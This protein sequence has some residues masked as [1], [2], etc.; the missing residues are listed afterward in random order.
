MEEFKELEL[1][2]RTIDALILGFNEP[3]KYDLKIPDAYGII[4]SVGFAIDRLFG[5]KEPNLK[6]RK[7]STLFLRYLGKDIIELEKR[8]KEGLKKV[9]V[10]PGRE[11]SFLQ[12]TL[13]TEYKFGQ[14]WFIGY[15][16]LF[17]FREDEREIAERLV[18][19][20]FNEKEREDFRKLHKYMRE[21]VS[22]FLKR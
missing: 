11:N 16:K 12:N 15:G 10:M 3:I 20:Y 17:R 5:R 7:L 13:L 22:K 4:N 9:L 14:E 19:D 18:R 21:Y 8:V 1:K 2:S 6:H